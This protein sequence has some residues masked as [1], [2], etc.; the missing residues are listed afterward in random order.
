[1]AH[2]AALDSAY[3]YKT[4]KSIPQFIKPAL[5]AF[6]YLLW[7]LLL[8]LKRSAIDTTITRMTPFTVPRWQGIFWDTQKCEPNKRGGVVGWNVIAYNTESRRKLF[9]LFAFQI[10]LSPYFGYFFPTGYKTR[11]LPEF[12]LWVLNL[13]S[14]GFII[15]YFWQ[16]LK[17]APNAE[18]DLFGVEFVLFFI[19]L[20]PGAR[21]AL[22]RT[23]CEQLSQSCWWAQCIW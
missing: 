19:V 17:W 2:F 3:V 9:R 18:S 21:V 11:Q 10:L 20:R 1:M 5:Y 13:I 15:S 4:T 14:K 6:E 23:P 22:S 16:K 12:E 7:K 8:L